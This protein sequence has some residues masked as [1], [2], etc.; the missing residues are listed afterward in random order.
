[1]ASTRASTTETS[2]TPAADRAGLGESTEGHV[3]VRTKDRMFT[4]RVEAVIGSRRLRLSLTRAS[5]LQDL[6]PA[7]DGPVPG[8]S[9]AGSVFASS[10]MEDYPRRRESTAGHVLSDQID[11]PV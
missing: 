4:P 11:G 7:V 6:D 9:T 5:T 8:R 10:S 1:M 3:F 2:R